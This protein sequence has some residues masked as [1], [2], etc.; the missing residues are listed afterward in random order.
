MSDKAIVVLSGGQDS[1]TCF[2]QAY[3]DC[4]GDISAVSFEYGQRHVAEINA[5]KKMCEDFKVPHVIV[6]LSTLLSNGTSALTDTSLEV[7]KPHPLMPGVPSSFVPMRNAIFLTAA[8]G[9]AMERGANLVY[10]GVCETDYSGYPDCRMDFAKALHKALT[11][12]YPVQGEPILFLTPLMYL[13]KAQ[14]FKMAA[15]LGDV[16]GITVLDYIIENSV[17]CYHGDV[18]TRHAWGTGCGKCPS[19]ELKAKGFAEYKMRY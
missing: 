11:L 6:D 13:D 9:L 17:T 2:A 7:G 12:G 1:M 18:T 15:D 16:A 8:Y 10:T 4:H 19:C 5:A 14:T 3:V